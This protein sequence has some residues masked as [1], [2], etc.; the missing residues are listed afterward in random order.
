MDR[1]TPARSASSPRPRTG[2]IPPGTYLPSSPP[3]YQAI[4]SRLRGRELKTCRQRH[5]SRASPV[6]DSAL[7]ASATPSQPRFACAIDE[8]MFDHCPDSAFA[9]SAIARTAIAIPTVRRKVANR[10]WRDD[11]ADRVS[12]SRRTTL[13]LSSQSP[14]RR[15][16][17][18]RTL[19]LDSPGVVHWC[20]H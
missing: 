15:M 7:V 1:A 11:L 19:I 5:Q 20:A 12:L 13:E 3:K 16:S 14:Q 4:A 6:I 2:Q 10:L 8:R 18:L 9:Q 17:T